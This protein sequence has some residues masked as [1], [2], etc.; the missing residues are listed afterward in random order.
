MRAAA[1]AV[2]RDA[3]PPVL[4]AAWHDAPY[5]IAVVDADLRA[6]WVNPAF[7][8]L[9]GISHSDHVGRTL[10]DLLPTA[11][12]SLEDRARESLQRGA[13]ISGVRVDAA[14]GGVTT[15]RLR[16]TIHPVRS[17]EGALLGACVMCADVTDETRLVEELWQT[18]KQLAASQL[19]NVFA[20]D[21][22]NLLVVIQG[23]CDLLV[24]KASDETLKD[25]LG[26]IR[27]AAEA[28]AG[29]SR[30]LLALSRRSTG[31]ASAVDLNLLLRTMRTAV[32]RALPPNI[33]KAFVFD[34]QLGLV[35]AEPGQLEQVVM[36]LVLQAA[37]DSLRPSFRPSTD[38]DINVTLVTPQWWIATAHTVGIA[39]RCTVAVFPGSSAGSGL[40]T[41][42]A[43]P[44]DS[45]AAVKK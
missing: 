11:H 43:T 8:M 4:V 27:S 15:R 39:S 29:L 20:H 25:R 19:A 45:V 9:T 31:A 22:N 34:E 10:A 42:A 7:A 23:Y 1:Q 26:R 41:C 38:V 5:A 24:M 14:A 36:T 28:A 21:F 2:T 30:Q 33:K 18:Q 32:E 44:A 35:L 40:A 6:R 16:A 3:L 37:L 13:P 17:N 12:P